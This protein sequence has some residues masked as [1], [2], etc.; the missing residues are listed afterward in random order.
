MANPPSWLKPNTPVRPLQYVSPDQY[1][2]N[3]AICTQDQ[4]QCINNWGGGGS[5]TLLRFYQYSESIA[6][7]WWNWW[8][9]GKVTLPGDP[10]PWPFTSGSG[11]NNDYQGNAVWKFGFSP[12]RTQQGSGNCIDQGLFSGNYSHLRTNG[13]VSPTGQTQTSSKYQYFVQDGNGRLIAVEATNILVAAEGNITHVWVG[14]EDFEQ[15]NGTY[16]FLVTD[17]GDAER[18]GAYL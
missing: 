9:E 10:N 16:V 5:G 4:D 17:L 7:N 1:S 6:N 14:T 13:C 18:W 8:Y 15:G 11:V 3:A 12:N 2:E